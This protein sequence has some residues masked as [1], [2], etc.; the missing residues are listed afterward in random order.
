MKRFNA[1]VPSYVAFKIMV[2]ESQK[3]YKSVKLK[4]VRKGSKLW[5]Y[6]TVQTMAQP[7]KSNKN[8]Q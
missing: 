4:K 1:T 7:L 5:N 2:I 8:Q 3:A 6:N